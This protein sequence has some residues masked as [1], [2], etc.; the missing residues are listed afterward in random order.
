MKKIMIPVLSLFV[1]AVM[2]CNS[3][4]KKHSHSGGDEPKT[5]AD[6]L[7]KDVDQVQIDGMGNMGQ[8]TKL[9]QQARKVLDSLNALP[10]KLTGAGLLYKEKLD[11]LVKDL[12]YAEFAMDKW[13]P[14]FYSNT[15]TLADNIS[16]RIKYLNNEKIKAS[17]IKDAILGGIQKTDSLLKAKF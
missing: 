17:K 7:M 11:S 14:E 12:D 16:E 15:D 2:S 9:Q 3:D 4:D 5:L 8:L 6:S 13:M 1:C 10:S